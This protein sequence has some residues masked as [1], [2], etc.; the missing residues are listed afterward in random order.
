MTWH[1]RKDMDQSYVIKNLV[2]IIFFLGFFFQIFIFI[3]YL[4]LHPCRLLQLL[5]PLVG[6]YLLLCRVLLYIVPH[7]RRPLH[8]DLHDPRIF[9]RRPRSTPKLGNGAGPGRRRVCWAPAPRAAAALGFLA[10]H[11]AAGQGELRRRHPLTF[12][13][14][15]SVQVAQGLL[16]LPL[17]ARAAN[18]TV[19][20]IDL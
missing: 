14:L 5:L 16:Q 13:S 17:T 4:S 6:F 2:F 8:R 1:G 20:T 18:Q 12:Y 19:A 15:T 10:A 9:D 11:P 3:I 7:V